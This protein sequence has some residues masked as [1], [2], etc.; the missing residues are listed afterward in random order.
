M[1]DVGH[2][3]VRDGVAWRIGAQ[4]DVAWISE[5]TQPGLAITSA[6][7]SVFADYATLVLPGEPVDQDATPPGPRLSN[8][9]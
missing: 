8:R 1:S 3:R 7:P 5:N 4:G 9:A 6:I 2:T